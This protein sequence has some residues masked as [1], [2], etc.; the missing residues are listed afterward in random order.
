MAIDLDALPQNEIQDA[1]GRIV[2]Q[3]G[4]PPAG[5]TQEGMVSSLRRATRGW[6]ATELRVAVAAAIDGCQWYPLAHRIRQY[7]PQSAGRVAA[8]GS[9][10]ALDGSA[11]GRCGTEPYLAGYETVGGDVIGRYRCDCPGYTG[12]WQTPAALSWRETER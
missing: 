4:R 1:V 7:R 8:T 10:Q 9:E 3:R 2:S 11:C 12:G 6:T 5:V